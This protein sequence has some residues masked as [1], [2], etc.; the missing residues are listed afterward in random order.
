MSQ[1]VCGLKLQDGERLILVVHPTL[2]IQ[3]WRIAAVAVLFFAPI[4]FLYPLFG[5]PFYGLLIFWLL[6]S[7]SIIWGLKIFIKWRGTVLLVTSQRLILS[8]KKKLFDRLVSSLTFDQI[9]DISLR[10]KGLWSSLGGYSTLSYVSIPTQKRLHFAGVRRAEAVVQVILSSAGHQPASPVINSVE[11]LQNMLRNIKQELG[12]EKF[13]NLL[14]PI[15]E[16]E[17]IVE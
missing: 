9:S 16:D 11:E 7:W 15:L 1:K 13:I 12:R 5:W 2:L 8:K 14:K 10:Q 6:L 3:A 17:S 4:F